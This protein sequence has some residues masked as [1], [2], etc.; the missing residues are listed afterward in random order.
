ME[1]SKNGIVKAYLRVAFAAKFSHEFILR[2]SKIRRGKNEK[3]EK[4][5]VKS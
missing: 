5:K 3:R 1:K 4:E 2:E